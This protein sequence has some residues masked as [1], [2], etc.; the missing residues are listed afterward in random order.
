MLVLAIK[1]LCKQVRVL[2][3]HKLFI[4]FFILFPSSLA[5]GIELFIPLAFRDEVLGEVRSE[6]DPDTSELLAVDA[7]TLSLLRGR[8]RPAAYNRLQQAVDPG[9]Q[10]LR[11]EDAAVLGLALNFDQIEIAVRA[12]P[13]VEIELPQEVTF[14]VRQRPNPDLLTPVSDLS[15]FLNLR[16]VVENQVIVQNENTESEFPLGL[17]V[18][19]AG[20][21]GPVSARVSTVI[22][23][24]PGED[25]PVELERILLRYDWPVQRVRLEGGTTDLPQSGLIGARRVLG[26][27]VRSDPQLDP[28]TA[29]R[30]ASATEL[31]LERPS[32]VDVRVNDRRIERLQLPAGSFE[33]RDYPL[34]AGLNKVE[35]EITDDLGRTEII[36]LTEPFSTQLL[37][38]GEFSYHAGAG[39]DWQDRES[40]AGSATLRYGVARRLSLGAGMQSTLDENLAALDASFATPVG[41]ARADVGIHVA[42]TDSAVELNRAL[43][44]EYGFGVPWRRY[45]PRVNVSFRLQDADYRTPSPAEWQGPADAARL[46]LSVSQSVVNRVGLSAIFQRRWGRDPN[47]NGNTISGVASFSPVSGATLAFRIGYDWDDDGNSGVRGFIGYTHTLSGGR[48]STSVGQ[49]LADNSATVSLRTAH[50]PAPAQRLTALGRISGFPVQGYDDWSGGASLRYVTPYFETSVQHDSE[51]FDQGSVER[52]HLSGVRLGTAVAYADGVFAP[53]RPI[54]EAFVI[55]RRDPSL[56]D[57]GLEVRSEGGMRAT[58]LE[59]WDRLVVPGLRAYYPYTFFVDAPFL[60]EGYDVG[61]GTYMVAPGYQH[62]V[63]IDIGSDARVYVE[64][65]LVNELGE[66]VPLAA[67]RK[68]EGAFDAEAVMAERAGTEEADPDGSNR[69]DELAQSAAEPAEDQEGELFFSDRDG[70]FVLYGLRPGT[71]HLRMSGGRYAE[72]SIPEGEVGRFELGDIFLRLPEAEE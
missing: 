29:R 43:N 55:F 1:A 60:P 9:T 35:L 40:A 14:G 20:A 42:E 47:P 18:E 39:L 13:A 23:S 68:H 71:Y 48:L 19:A 27:S 53:S 57:V 58:P 59:R 56:S 3:R 64:G 4:L 36:L 33:L 5:T 30:T 70:I 69:A 32:E 44:L 52:R 61:P 63:L 38:P 24:D 8:L 51:F 72:F 67:G 34:A 50:E 21:R 15:A 46:R 16:G 26:A 2:H 45:L 22:E 65:R 6:I 12:E 66:A 41:N 11:V 17:G 49:D 25:D 10:M 7:D 28:Y 54:S 37:R 31:F 62:G